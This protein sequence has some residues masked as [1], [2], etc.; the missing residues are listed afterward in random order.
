VAREALAMAGFG[1][2]MHVELSFS[3][4]ESM[5]SF[6]LPQPFFDMGCQK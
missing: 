6:W 5:S 1:A 3:H 4:V 2:S